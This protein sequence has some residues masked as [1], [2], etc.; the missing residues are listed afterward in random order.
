MLTP[1][2]GCELTELKGVENRTNEVGV[3]VKGGGAIPTGSQ[4]LRTMIRSAFANMRLFD[5]SIDSSENLKSCL[6]KS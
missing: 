6:Y 3:A 4:R 5:C 1:Q 2:I